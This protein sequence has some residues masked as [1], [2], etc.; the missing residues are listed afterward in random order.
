MYWRYIN[1]RTTSHALDRGFHMIVATPGRLQ[2]MLQKKKFNLDLCK[3]LCMDEA[4][5]MIDMGFE[6]DVRNI[7]TYFKVSKKSE[8]NIYIYIYGKRSC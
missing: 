3:Y 7:M 4:D 6:D 5:R 8:R 2:D 1:A